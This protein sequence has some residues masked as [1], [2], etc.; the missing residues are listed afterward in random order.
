MIKFL[1]SGVATRR[2]LQEAR[3]PFGVVSRCLHVYESGATGATPEGFAIFG[4]YGV[5][6]RISIVRVEH[7]KDRPYL[8]VAKD[9]V[10]DHTVPFDARGFLCFLLAKP[11]DW[12]VR[13]EEIARECGLHFTTIYKLLRKLIQAGYVHR[14]LIARRKPNGTFDSVSL[15]TVF[16]D[17]KVADLYGSK[18][19]F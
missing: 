18:I 11:D 16:E 19:P 14:D 9:T 8:V 10:R 12:Q 2:A 5:D 15:Y 1:V 6:G 4:A 13:P 7:E 3:D 17:R